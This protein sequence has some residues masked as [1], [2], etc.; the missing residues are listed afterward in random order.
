MTNSTLSVET[1]VQMLDLKSQN[2][3]QLH[4]GTVALSYGRGLDSPWSQK[5]HGCVVMKACSDEKKKGAGQGKGVI[6]LTS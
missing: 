3:V 1:L 2:A 6:S 4:G 5:T